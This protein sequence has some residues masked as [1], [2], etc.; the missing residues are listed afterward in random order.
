MRNYKKLLTLIFSVLWINSFTQIVGN[1]PPYVL[2]VS[3][4][5]GWTSI[6]PNAD[7]DLIADEDL[8]PRFVNKSTQLDSTLSNDL[9]ISWLPDGMGNFA[10]YDNRQAEF[11]LYNFT[12]WAYID[13]LVWFGGTFEETVQIPSAPWTNAA[14]INGVKVLANVFFPPNVFGGTNAKL[15]EWLEKDSNGDF[16]VID[17]MVEI[18]R[19]YNFD[20]WFINQETNTNATI[21]SQMREF[22]EQLTVAVEEFG[23]EVMWY[24][25][26]LINGSVNWQNR[27]NSSNS[28]FLQDDADNDLSNGYETRVSSNMFIN[29][30]WNGTSGPSAS[31]TQAAEIGRS[32]FEVITGVDLWPGRNQTQF[33]LGGNVWMSSL[34]DNNDIPYTSLGF[35]APSCLFNNATYSVFNSDPDDYVNFYNSE[36]H[37]FAGADGIPGQ[38]DVSG[39][40]GISNWVPASSTITQVPFITQFNTGHG[41]KKFRDGEVSIDAPWHYMTDQDILPT[42]QFA[43]SQG[44]ELDAKFDFVDV[45]EGGSSLNISGNLNANEPIDLPLFKTNLLIDIDTRIDLVFKTE[46]PN[47]SVLNVV[48]QFNDPNVEDAVFTLTHDEEDTWRR[49]SNLLSDYIGESIAVIGLRFESTQDVTD[50]NINIGEISVDV[51]DL[52]SSTV[53]INSNPFDVEIKYQERQRFANIGEYSGKK[54]VFTLMD[55]KGTVLSSGNINESERFNYRIPTEG[56]AAGSYIFS[57]TDGIEVSS[58]KFVL[59]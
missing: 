8:K 1:K 13:K 32:E 42:W 33:E 48:L 30:F 56:L 25:S 54:L 55:V 18:M 23:G 57:V 16:V 37:L 29:F 58:S 10:N 19:F 11:N 53:D 21:G 50:Y 46:N 26:M 2:T 35:F 20:G 44:S 49:K 36:R 9:E 5:K 22:L 45:L 3:Q 12:H 27:L 47:Q 31:K 38:E 7:F 28:I 17:K 40:K 6:G 4:L 41:L 39:F 43:F 14:H 51:K 24:D 34:F 52:S 59:P 15:Q